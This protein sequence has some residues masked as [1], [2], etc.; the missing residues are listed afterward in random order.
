M[1]LLWQWLYLSCQTAQH[2]V[3]PILPTI[4]SECFKLAH[5]ITSIPGGISN[6]LQISLGK[7]NVYALTYALKPAV[8]PITA[9]T[10]L[11]TNIES[12]KWTKQNLLLSLASHIPL[13]GIF[14]LYMMI[15]HCRSY[16]EW[17]LKI[18]IPLIYFIISNISCGLCEA[19]IGIH[20]PLILYLQFILWIILV[21]LTPLFG[22]LYSA[23]I[24]YLVFCQLP[25]KPPEE[26]ALMKY[27][28]F[29]PKHTTIMKW[30]Q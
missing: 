25:D 5:K 27:S 13:Q 2:V 30:N 22:V 24:I 10:T 14:K 17:G 1:F 18:M 29:E 3:T 9:L 4:S 11:Q 7:L 28:M 16:I 15:L 20:L 26:P 6:R 12:S 21:Y 19:W 23:L 8:D